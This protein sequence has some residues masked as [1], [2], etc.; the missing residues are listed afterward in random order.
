[1]RLFAHNGLGNDPNPIYIKS[2]AKGTHLSR[3]D[4]QTTY[5]KRAYLNYRKSYGHD[6]IQ[7]VRR[8]ISS[9]R[10][11]VDESTAQL[12]NKPKQQQQYINLKS[13]TKYKQPA[14]IQLAN[15]LRSNTSLEMVEESRL[16]LP[17]PSS[18]CGIG[19]SNVPLNKKA[20]A[21]L[22]PALAPHDQ[23]IIYRKEKTARIAN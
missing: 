21:K 10:V 5:A 14:G 19:M 15:K 12:S 16:S 7:T 11:S 17:N 13:S 6:A 1:M 4:E 22:L 20:Q 18:N 2:S 8:S 3:E 9:L 23:Q